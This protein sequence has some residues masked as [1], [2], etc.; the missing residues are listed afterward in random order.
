MSG[1]EQPV[2]K[3]TFDGAKGF[4]FAAAYEAFS[5]AFDENDVAERKEQLNDL[6]SR[7]SNDEISYPLY[8]NELNRFREGEDNRE[9]RRVRIQGQRKRAYRRDQQEKD[10]VK[11]H[12]R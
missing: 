4:K 8:Y 1:E 9:F 12:K 5:K 6:V 2:S 11:R 7:L 10:R 3:I